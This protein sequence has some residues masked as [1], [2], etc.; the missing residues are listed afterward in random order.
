MNK[1]KMLRVRMTEEEFEYLKKIAQNNNTTMS[2]YV[3]S[4]IKKEDNQ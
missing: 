4:L 1:T 3:M 2:A